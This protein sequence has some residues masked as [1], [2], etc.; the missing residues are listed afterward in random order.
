MLKIS[1]VIPSYNQ[2]AYLEET[3]LSI[4][5]QNYSELEIFV[6]D[7]NSKDN[8]VEVIRK[9]EK[10][11]T[12]WESVPD[13]GQSHAI[14][15]G[16]QRATGDIV[17]WLCSDDYYTEGALKKVNEMFSALPESTGLIFGSSRI[18]NRKGTVRTDKGFP[19]Q[20]NERVFAG[21]SFPQPS[22]F[23]RRSVLEKAGLLEDNL[24]YGMDYDLFSR[25]KVI[26]DFK[27]TDFCFSNYRLHEVGKT[28]M[29]VGKFIGE[30]TKVFNS[31]IA[32]LELSVI[33]DELKKMSFD[34]SEIER[35]KTF[36]SRHK[37]TVRVDQDVLLYNFL[38]NV[39]RF[40]YASSQI[41]RCRLIGNY[42]ESHF[43]NKLILEPEIQKIIKR[44]RLPVPV[45]L[46]LRR[47]KAII[48]TE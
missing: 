35:T 43:Q 23:F 20:T 48:D 26:C 31:I 12:Y 21:M 44:S 38:V 5:N 33:Q 41:Q 46:L 13:N 17:T 2:G 6:F 16:L 18:F 24:H 19:E 7:G 3:I 28:T 22:A 34:T 10:H 15:K 42:L 37:N 40:D 9:Y 36:F 27:S 1:V 30:W 11:L 8:S 29:A 47:V 14:N 25:L 32:G 45:I 39:I 4:I